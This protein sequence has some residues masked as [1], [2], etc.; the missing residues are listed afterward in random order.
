MAAPSLCVYKSIRQ[1]FQTGEIPP[2]GT[3]CEPDL[4]PLIGRAGMR[5]MKGAADGK[6]W[7][8]ILEVHQQIATGRLPL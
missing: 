2:S 8:A 7:D 3:I 4:R 5:D 1:Y 6:L